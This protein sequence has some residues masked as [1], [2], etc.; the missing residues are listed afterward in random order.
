M[1][2]IIRCF[3]ESKEVTS[4]RPMVSMKEE[5]TSVSFILHDGSEISLDEA[6]LQRG[7]AVIEEDRRQICLRSKK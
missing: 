3:V 2:A 4:I 7:L 6:T 5:T 1:K